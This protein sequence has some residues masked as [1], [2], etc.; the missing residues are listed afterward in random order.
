MRD[1]SN[2]ATNR[3]ER[4]DVEITDIRTGVVRAST[5]RRWNLVSVHTDTGHVGY[6]ESYR[7]AA[8]PELVNYMKNFLVGENPLDVERLFRRMVQETSGHGGT[9]GKIVSAATG[10]EIALWDVAG[11]ILDVPTYQLLGGKYRDEVRMYCDGH[12]GAP[13]MLKGGYQELASDE[14]FAPEAYERTANRILDMGFDA[15]KFDLDTPMD[16]E[17]DPFNGRV[18]NESLAHKVE[19]VETLRDAVGN[20]IDLAFDCHWDYSIES[21]KRVAKALEPYD[22]MWLE[23]LVP[24]ENIDAQ[25]EVTQSTSTPITTGENRFRTHEFKDLIYNFA[26]D[27]LSPD[28][29][30]CGGLAETKAI[31]NRAEENYMLIAPH[32]TCSPIGTIA[33]V[34]LCCAIPNFLALE[35][36][37]KDVEWWDDLHTN[38]DPLIQDGYI[39]VPERPGLGIEL[40]EDVARE[41]LA[42]PGTMFA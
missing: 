23:D 30:H 16:N 2:H 22:L 39:E 12:A 5:N 41:H 38:P 24:P 35:F 1:F 29:A 27:I 17:P 31:A 32:N 3:R 37:A 4:Q 19:V 21:A 28:T 20:K 6:G 10:V 26:T 42:D 33:N 8:I 9:T 25:R 18:S 40:N 34:H 14:E 15:M 11:K 13:R 7:G 36:H